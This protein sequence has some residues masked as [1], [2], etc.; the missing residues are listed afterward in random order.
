MVCL[1]TPKSI[2]SKYQRDIFRE[3][4][5]DREEFYLEKREI[6]WATYRNRGIGHCDIDYFIQNLQ[7]KYDRIK[8][9]Y[10]I[11]IEMYLEYKRGEK[12]LS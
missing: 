11:K 1:P 12:D 9:K 3:T 2:L 6:L 10:D 7:D 8:S 5:N 4:I